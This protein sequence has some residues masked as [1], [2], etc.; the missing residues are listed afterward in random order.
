MPRQ[1]LNAP[2]QRHKLYLNG[3]LRIFDSCRCIGTQVVARG[4][5]GDATTRKQTWRYFRVNNVP[6]AEGSGIRLLY[7]RQLC[8]GPIS[9]EIVLI[10]FASQA[11]CRY[12]GVCLPK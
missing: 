4:V 3:D 1:D 11:R 10:L 12:V 2:L 9:G 5:G 8:L 7:Y 6:A